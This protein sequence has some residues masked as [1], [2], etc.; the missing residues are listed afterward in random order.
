MLG[1][2]VLAVT[3]TAADPRPELVEL[4]LAGQQQQALAR[5]EQEMAEQPELARRLGLGYLYGHLLDGA[6]HPGEASKAFVNAIGETPR[7]ELYSRYRAALDLDRLGHPEMAAGLVAKVPASA[8][9]SPLV[10]EAVWL[11]THTLREGGDCHLL[12]GLRPEALPAPQR[13]EIQLAQ[14]DCA[15]RTGYLDLGRS[16]LATLL[17]ENRADE[18]AHDAADRLAGVISDAERGRLPM[19]IG[20]TFHQHSEFDRAVRRLQQAT[21]QGDALSGL[22]A[23]ETQLMLGLSLLAQQRYSEASAVF[24]RLAAA[25]RSPA[26]RA[27]ALYHEG[28]AHE[29]RG[30]WPAAA[31]RFRQAYLAEPQG[32]EWAAPALLAALR[33][34]WRNGAEASALPLY[35][36]LIGQPEWRGEAARAALFL[37]ASDLVRGRRDRA[38]PWLAQALLGGPDDRLEAEYWSGRLAELEN[39]GRGAVARYLEVLRAEPNHPL[40][41]AARARLA[42]EPLARTAA[43]EGRRLASS[44]HLDDVYGAWLLLGDDDAAGKAAQRRLEQRL[45]AD[46]SAAPYLRLAE[47]PVARWPLWKSE[48]SDPPEMLL[49]LGVWHEGAPAI[50]E[51]FPLSDPSLAFTGAALLARGGDVARA[52]AIA[53]ALR[54]R[55]PGRL[56]LA[57]QPRAYRRLL[58]PWPYRDTFLAQARI[59]GVDAHLLAALIREESRFDTSALS[60]AASRGLNGLAPATAHRLAVQLNL[61]RLAP[62]DYYRPQVS[63]ALGAAYLAALLKD[64]AGAKLP[65]LAAYKTGEIQALDWRNQCFSQEPEEYFTKIGRR[66]TRTFAARVLEGRA[67]YAEL[68]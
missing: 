66:E 22:E 32:R 63:I 45:L 52:I 1:T 4:Q 28:L 46:R 38:R 30:A 60:P 41:A 17:D 40:A 53:E 14:G 25:A 58:Y 50:G 61:E 8:P 26:E 64:F 54:G 49:A 5:V 33:L 10:P 19:L 11:L 29:L 9:R 48:L 7:L 51:H 57:L 47:V 55:A 31:T 15:L 13:R 42:A 65:A 67:E 44:R 35:Q 20:F 23:Y 24:S 12:R 2:L 18:A 56:P 37:A 21:G 36:R 62:Q 27:R 6:R 3:I 43:A 16:L 68:Y 39:D 34:E 59:R